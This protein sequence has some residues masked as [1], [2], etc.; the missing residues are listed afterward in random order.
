MKKKSNLKKKDEGEWMIEDFVYFGNRK[1]VFCAITIAT[2]IISI[3]G[4]PLIIN[5]QNFL[6]VFLIIW[7]LEIIYI[8]IY[9]KWG[10]KKSK[11]IRNLNSQP[12]ILNSAFLFNFLNLS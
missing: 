5:N 2:V 12:I 7:I 1:D 4:I 9:V 11:K 3:V 8:A 6:K 10:E